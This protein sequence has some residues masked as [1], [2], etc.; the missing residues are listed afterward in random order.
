MGEQPLTPGVLEALDRLRD[1]AQRLGVGR[2]PV[3]GGR[4]V[5][6]VLR[7]PGGGFAPGEPRYGLPYGI[8][9]GVRVG[10][11]P[12]ELALGRGDGPVVGAAGPVEL[13]R[14]PAGG[15]RRQFGFTAGQRVIQCA[16]GLGQ[17]RDAALPG[18]GP[19]G[20][21]DVGDVGLGPAPRGAGQ[22]PGAVRTDRGAVLRGRV[23][24]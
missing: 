13:Q 3:F 5:E 19:C 17:F 14:L 21:P 8:V 6:S 12:V 15:D 16:D 1:R 10:P 2:Q 11:G 9:P 20:G 23:S 18:P 7:G 24:P 4:V 22:P